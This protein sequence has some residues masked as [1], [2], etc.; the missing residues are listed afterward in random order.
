MT[1]A[2]AKTSG[3]MLQPASFGELMQFAEL[4][5]KST[6]APKDYRGNPGNC[7]VAIQLGA[8]VGLQPMQALQGIAVVAGKPSLY[9]DAFLAVI[10]ASE[11]FQDMHEDFDVETGT[12]ICT[13]HRKGR[14]PVTRT[15]SMD[16]A[17][18]ANLSGKAGPWKEYPRRMCAMRA[19]AWAGRDL[20][21]DVLMG[22]QSAEEME[23][24][25]APIAAKAEVVRTPKADPT[26][27]LVD[28][29]SDKPAMD[30]T[31]KV[32]KPKFRWKANE[33]YNNTYI[34][35]APSTVITDYILF[36][37]DKVLSDISQA[38]HHDAARALKTQ[39][40]DVLR[41]KLLLE[42]AAADAAP[43]IQEGIGQAIGDK[44][45]SMIDGPLHDPSDASEEWG[46]GR[47]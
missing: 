13:M 15:F 11:H 42:H 33:R 38:K 21:A 17:D 43:K 19:R 9:G 36:L 6:L 35:Q 5:S 12:A 22:L 7:V 24:I 30:I 27:S 8:A 44:L 25:P 4:I 1:D 41:V 40:E 39:A 37:N 31:T 16:D 3:W 26:P 10:Q 18:R 14:S 45:Q 2:L 34:E 23:D 29:V 32:E 47:E 28:M 20:F 46:I